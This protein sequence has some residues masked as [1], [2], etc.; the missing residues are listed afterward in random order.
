MSIHNR[1]IRNQFLNLIDRKEGHAYRKISM[2]T[3]VLKPIGY[4]SSLT[5]I[6]LAL[7]LGLSFVIGFFKIANYDIWWHMKT[8][9][10]ILKQGI[11][12]TDPFSFTAFGNHW[13]THEWLA[14]VI[15]Y[16][17]YQ[18]GG[19]TVLI[20]FKGAVSAA[21][22]FLIFHFGMKNGA[23][24]PFS[25]AV[26]MLAVAAMSY[27]MYARPH[28]F[29]F[30]FLAIIA[31]V[32]FGSERS[33]RARI[34]Q[35][36]VIVPVV[37][38]LWANMHAGFILGLGVYWVVVA[39]EFIF[40][41]VR[42]LAASERFM[43]SVVPASLATLLCLVNPNGIDIFTYPIMIAGNPVFKS[44]IG[45]WV[46]PV[47]IGKREWL[48]LT[49]L[50]LSSILGIV[51]AAAH[52]KRRPDISLIMIAVGVSAWLAVRNIQ[53]FAIVLAP[54]ILTLVPEWAAG[55]PKIKP[56]FARAITVGSLIWIIGIFLMIRD[57]QGTHNRL[58]LGIQ[59]GLVP[60]G[61]ARYLERIGFEGNI[62]NILSDG[63][64]LIWAG[65][66]RWRVFVDGRLDVYGEELITEYRRLIEGSPDAPD[67]FERLKV[68][69]AVL[70]MPPL[71][72]AVRNLLSKDPRWALAY[73]DDYYIVFLNKQARTAD[74]IGNLA[75]EKINPLQTGYGIAD[76]TEPDSLLHE[77]ERAIG[78]E[79]NSS[80]VN[81]IYAQALARKNEHVRA[82]DYYKKAL[83]IQPGRIEFYRTIGEMYL[84]ANASDSASAWLFKAL[85]VRP[86][87]PWTY[88][89]L[90]MLCARQSRFPEAE[91]YFRQAVALDPN[92][93]AQRML[94]RLNALK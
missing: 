79:P 64:Y 45:E 33:P 27:M 47:Y 68:G 61:P 42:G 15:F 73:F 65:C 60:E 74:S 1:L 56:Y 86:N 76:D 36:W 72:G 84:H 46:S 4:K 71:M 44:T 21:I 94:E 10:L 89:D 12:Q 41:P 38:W 22:A 14:E 92:N 28:A 59:R 43:R 19:L 24:A 35:R 6:F 85:K 81:A 2:L 29:S 63:G 83:S 11:P 7:V 49:I 18:M 87:D 39:T 5:L 67:K 37:L 23:S 55:R 40:P 78:F 3:P 54:A 91:S 13:V 90:G 70:P 77:A 26:S 52:L 34:W 69:A 16:L 30:L 51:A 53:N 9:E 48:A 20:L 88:F 58:G 8:G 25:A 75:F 93:P 31:Y 66:P 50:S 32:L 80:L 57:Y 17:L 82:A 62:A